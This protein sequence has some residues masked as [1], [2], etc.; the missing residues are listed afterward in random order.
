MTAGK[1]GRRAARELERELAAAQEHAKQ[2]QA[3]VDGLLD[4]VNALLMANGGK[5]VVST[6]QIV[7]ASRRQIEVLHG[8]DRVVITAVQ[9]GAGRADELGKSVL[10][11]LWLPR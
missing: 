2:A 3:N 6:A 11:Q 9:D 8:P 5:L 10:S 4:I 1:L 7:A